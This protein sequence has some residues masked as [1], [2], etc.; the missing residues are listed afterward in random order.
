MALNSA[1]AGR[2]KG[3]GSRGGVLQ[4]RCLTQR[5]L[6]SRRLGWGNSRTTAAWVERRAGGAKRRGRG[7]QSGGPRGARLLRD[8]GRKGAKLPHPASAACRL[9]GGPE[10]GGDGAGVR[11]PELSAGDGPLLLGPVHRAGH[12]DRRVDARRQNEGDAVHLHLDP[13][14]RQQGRERELDADRPDERVA[15]VHRQH[16]LLGQVLRRQPHILQ[17]DEPST[18]VDAADGVGRVAWDQHV[19]Q[20]LLDRL[21]EPLHRSK[22][23]ERF[24]PGARRPGH[25][26]PLLRRGWSALSLGRTSAGP[27]GRSVSNFKILK[28]C[29]LMFDVCMFVRV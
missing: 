9:A 28:F 29:D 3:L 1:C 22:T 5:R 20:P 11:L 12:R 8:T 15:H 24:R 17:L 25:R 14:A 26:R 6:A 7:A 2:K 18:Q 27:D 13:P 23:H 4:S 16:R 19:A 10:A 21:D